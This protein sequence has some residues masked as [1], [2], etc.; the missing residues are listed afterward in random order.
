MIG[1]V[2][3]GSEQMGAGGHRGVG[4]ID[5]AFAP[6]QMWRYKD[7]PMS[8]GT[9]MR[10]VR[11]SATQACGVVYLVQVRDLESG[12]RWFQTWIDEPSL[13]ASVIELTE[14]VSAATTAL[15]QDSDTS[16]EFV[17]SCSLARG[18]M[19]SILRRQ[20][21]LRTG[22]QLEDEC[23]RESAQEASFGLRRP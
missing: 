18:S 5:P 6:G 4:E 7:S 10:V 22:L 9:V 16:K 14:G 11:A 17:M 19:A 13:A 1:S 21:E 20:M 23:G 8:F 3:A 15:T 12:G 2:R